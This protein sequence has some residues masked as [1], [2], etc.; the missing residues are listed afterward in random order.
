MRG[1]DFRFQRLDE[2]VGY[3]DAGQISQRVAGWQAARIDDSQCR[4]QP[5][6]Q[7]MMVGDDGIDALLPSQLD[8]SVRVNARIAGQQQVKAVFQVVLQGRQMNAMPFAES[9][10][11]VHGDAR[12]QLAERRA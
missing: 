11:Q 5:L 10:G 7:S 9:V 12:A 1:G 2:L 6:W 3:A 4:G 8:R